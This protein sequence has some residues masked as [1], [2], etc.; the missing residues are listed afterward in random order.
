MRCPSLCLSLSLLLTLAPPVAP[1]VHGQAREGENLTVEEVM[2]RYIEAMGGRVALERINSARL[3][4]SVLDGDRVVST[5]TVLKKDPDRVRVVIDHGRSRFVQ[6]YDGETVWFSRHAGGQVFHGRMPG[7]QAEKFINEAPLTNYLV[8]YRE[9]PDLVFELGEDVML[10]RIPC[11]KV[12]ARFPDGSWNVHLIDKERFIERRIYEYDADGDRLLELIPSQ[13]E[14]FGGVD[15]AMRIIRRKKG[16][17]MS[18]LV[19]NE[20]EINIGIL[21]D[22]FRPPPELV[23]KG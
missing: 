1:T 19:L 14:R 17:N 21:E 16:E 5:I 15:F 7:A 13:F 6:G 2:D 18:T 9:E 11:Y 12:I 8:R 10:N 22:A 20:V 3:R 4:G 23:G